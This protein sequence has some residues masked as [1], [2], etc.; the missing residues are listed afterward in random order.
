MLSNNKSR[1][2]SSFK[3][4][5]QQIK[6]SGKTPEQILQDLIASGKISQSDLDLA[7]KKAKA[8][9]GQS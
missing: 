8:F 6:N 7:V 1:L 9:L 4:F 5:E 2:S 3:I